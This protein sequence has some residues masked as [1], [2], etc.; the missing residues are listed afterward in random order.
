MRVDVIN[1]FRRHA[2]DGARLAHCD[3]SGA[4]FGM[5]LR[6][7]V[8]VNGRGVTGDFAENFRVAF[9]RAFER[10]QREHRRAFAHGEAVAVFVK[11]TAARRRQRLQ[12]VEAG[13]NQLAQNVVAAGE[14][15]FRR[16]SAEEFP[17]L[18]DG[19]GTGCAGVGNDVHRSAQAERV[20][21]NPAL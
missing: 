2:R 17:R 20:E 14:N 1:F 19:A 12:R 4:A 15:F 6:E 8:P 3:E 10:F 7:M 16:A 9:L 21:H 5:R 11:R 13:K 18:A